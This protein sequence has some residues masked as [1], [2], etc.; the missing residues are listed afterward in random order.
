LF[1][2]PE[3]SVPNVCSSH[4]SSTLTSVL[5]AVTPKDPLQRTAPQPAGAELFSQQSRACQD[6]Q[7]SGLLTEVSWSL[8]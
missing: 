4:Y 8:A 1:K 6:L 5:G 3:R 2:K 7:Q